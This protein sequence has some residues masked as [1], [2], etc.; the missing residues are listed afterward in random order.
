MRDL[1]FAIRQLRKSPGFT[2]AAVLSLGLGIGANTAIFQLVNAIRLRTLPARDPQTLAYIDFAKGSARSGSFSTRSAR[3]TYTQWQ[4][5]RARQQAFSGIMAWSATRY[6]LASGGEGRYV[7]GMFVSGEFFNLL[8]VEPAIGR[9]FTAA[10]DS[11]SCAAPGAVISSAFWQREFSGAPGVLDRTITLN[12]H[13]FPIIGVTPPGFFGVEVGRQYDVAIPLCADRLLAENHIGRMPGRTS[14]WLS[15]MGR[16]KPGWT[17]EAAKAHLR[18]ISP[19]FMQATLPPTYRPEQAKRFVANKLDVSDGSAGVSDLRRAYENPLWILMAATTLVL[20]IACANLANLLLARAGVR[21]REIAVRLAIGAGRARLVRQLL[22]E[23]LLLAAGGAVLGAMLATV[24]SRALVA[25]ISTSDTRFFVGLDPD[26]RTL[27]FTA[28]IAVSTCILF[29]LAPALR[30]THLSPIAALRGA[31]RAITSGKQRVTLRRLLVVAQVALSFVLL[32][33]CLLFVRSLQ[34]LLTADPGFKPEGIITVSVNTIPA[35]YAVER[36]PAITRDLH[37]RLAAIPGVL[38][39]VQVYITPI[40]GSSWNNGVGTDGTPAAGGNKI[41]MF[42]AVGPG[43]FHLMG[44]PVLAGREFDDRDKLGTPQVAVVNEVFAK[45]FLGGANPVGH[46]FRI[47]APA[48]KQ[49]QM[50][51]IVGLVKNSKYDDLRDEF[52]PTGYLPI[53]QRE[54][55]EPDPTFMIRYRG[56]PTQFIAGA[57]QSIAGLSPAIIVDF[58]K[59]SKQMSE[60]LLREQLMAALS[61]AFAVLAALLAALGLYSVIAYMV[62]RRRNEIGVRMAL[63]AGGGQVVRL[64]LREAVI[65]LFIGLAAGIAISLFATRA[66]AT[67]LYGL[68]PQDPISLVIAIAL[69]TTI[70]LV[71]AWAP[72]RRAAALDPM[73]A[74][75]DDG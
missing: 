18:A 22:A 73:N 62:V 44:T 48:G 40:S 67:L 31:G 29:G 74:L 51:Q 32:T 47:D 56:S 49:E 8:G 9:T 68:K 50:Y 11:E 4:D 46:T 20:L 15:I 14:W 71:A 52:P 1:R 3:F 10:D 5:L 70:A 13:A 24:L 59:F 75:R 64:V 53:A 65:L 57:K 72:A 19:A 54:E 21:E 30:A 69:L 35:H 2:L 25:F 33:G 12:G 66:A 60:S 41:S 39:A 6:N 23:S 58:T 63:G 7:D 61:T 27:G 28:A 55:S 36:R 16:L 26:W 34:Y 37:D 43:Y 38:G 17:V 45:K 42:N